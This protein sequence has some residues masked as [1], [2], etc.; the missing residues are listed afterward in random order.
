MCPCSPRVRE[1]PIPM[2]LLT[3]RE[4]ALLRLTEV[5]L[6]ELYVGNLPWSFND[7]RL[8]TLFA[9]HGEVQRAKIVMDRD[10]GRS[11]GFG[12]VTM[13]DSASAE[14]A[15]QALN[16][17]SHEGRTITVRVAEE[18]KE[19]SGP[20]DRPQRARGGYSR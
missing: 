17:Q 20:S 2:S 19:R 7:D 16:G 14:K 11:R 12:F 4:D 1:A 3:S 8:T 5:I 15:I 9:A 18:R 10:T 6:L 13:G